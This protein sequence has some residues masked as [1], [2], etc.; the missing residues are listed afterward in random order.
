MGG[1]GGSVEMGG[2]MERPRA[3]NRWS[4]AVQEEKGG[5]HKNA[6]PQAGPSR[7]EG[8]SY[9]S[10]REGAGRATN[11]QAE[12]RGKECRTEANKGQKGKTTETR[13][14]GRGHRC[15]RKA[16]GRVKHPGKRKGKCKQRRGGGQKSAVGEVEGGSG[17]RR[18]RRP[19]RSRPEAAWRGN[20][21]N[22]REMVRIRQAADKRR[23][24]WPSREKRQGEAQRCRRRKQAE[25]A[26]QSRQK[27]GRVRV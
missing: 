22:Q 3:R 16:A 24:W 10:A 25:G 23:T 5:G 7:R 2:R 9:R 21:A 8:R 13:G 17:A 11:A 18:V 12:R 27:N 6:G 26:G 4:S 20:Q 14:G 15:G 1:R 19:A